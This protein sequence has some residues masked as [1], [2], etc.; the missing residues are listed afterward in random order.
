MRGKHLAIGLLLVLLLGLCPVVRAEGETPAGRI[1]GN[2]SPYCIL[3]NRAANTVTVYGLD[4]GGTYSVP[5]RAMVCST[6]REGHRTPLGTF[7][8]T[9]VKNAW[10]YMVDGSY[11]QYAS[12][13]K[14]NYLFHSVCYTRADPSTLMTEEYNA[15][16]EAASRGCVRLQTA[17]AKWI[18]DNCPAGTRVTVYESDDPGPLGKP[19]TLVGTIGEEQP[20]SWDPSDGREDN[21]WRALLPERARLSETALSLAVGDSRALT[22]LAEGGEGV[23]AADSLVWVS[24]DPAVAAVDSAGNVTA[25]GEGSAEIRALSRE[26]GLPTADKPSAACL[27]SRIPYGDRITPALLDRVGR[28]EALVA[29]R[30]PG[31][32]QLRVRAHG[33]LARIEVA[34]ADIPRLSANLPA[35]SAALRPLGFARVEVDPRGYRT[36]SLNEALPPR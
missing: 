13:F 1:R 23:F 19:G 20:G 25:A 32:A 8:I 21:P 30:F 31:L 9:G 6:G 29:D 10:C 35:I 27:A 14:G 22:V 3:V 16:G 4:S 11:G 5:L 28:A 7:A 18:F 2:G 36:G 34:P 17:D 26:L 12:Q 24:T 33:D 15:L